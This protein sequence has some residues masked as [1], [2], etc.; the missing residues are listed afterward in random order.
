MQVINCQPSVDI[1]IIDYLER[2]RI[3]SIEL[4]ENKLDAVITE[5]CDGYF[6]INLSKHQMTHLIRQLQDL[7]DRM[8]ELGQQVGGDSR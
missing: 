4:S 3:F 5:Q 1:N 7:T 2:E 6:Q 8:M